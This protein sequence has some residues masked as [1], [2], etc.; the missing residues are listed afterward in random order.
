MPTA[1]I[2]K[3]PDDPGSGDV[4]WFD[5]LNAFEKQETLRQALYK[6]AHW[7]ELPDGQWSKRPG[8]IYPHILPEGHQ[9][10][11][12]FDPSV[13]DYAEANNIAFHT[14]SLNLRSSQ[15]CCLNFLYSLRQG[16]DLA[17][18]VLKPWLSDLARVTTIEFEYTGPPEVTDWLGEPPAGKRGQNRTSADAVIWWENR[19]GK[20]KRTVLEWK[21]TEKEFGSCGGFHSDG[22]RQ[23]ARCLTLDA[24]SIEPARDCYLALGET[25][26][27]RR[28]YWEHMEKAGIRFREFTGK[29]C[30]FRGPLYQLMRL[31]LLAAWLATNTQNNA[32]VAVACFQGNRLPMISPPYLSYLDRY[33]PS[34]WQCLLAE[35]NRFRVMFVEDLMAY[36]DSLPGVARLPWRTYLM[37]RYGI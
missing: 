25:P 12:F 14:E 3:L 26:R 22:N 34:A 4:T 30:P 15:A 35:P 33:L 23:K 27:N 7:P 21:Y 6:R 16:L 32:E 24:R 11:A 29:G 19:D 9:E 20:P 13:M 31:Q 18:R 17:S 1:V 37:E 5:R 2:H 8:Y 28:R 10:K 36:C